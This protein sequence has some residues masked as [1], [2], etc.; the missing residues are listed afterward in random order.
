MNVAVSFSLPNEAL[1]LLSALGD[2]GAEA[3]VVGGFVR[4]SLLGRSVSDIDMACSA[5]WQEMQRICEAAGF[6][7]HETGTKH[8]TLTVIVDDTAFEVTTFRIDGIYKDGRRPENVTFTQSI[9]EDLARRDFTINAMAYRPDKGLLDPFGGMHDIETRTI[10]TVGDPSTRFAEDGL[11]LLRACRFSAE[12]GY[13]IEKNTYRAMV[14]SKRFLRQISAERVTHELNRLLLGPCA[15]SALVECV[16][17]LSAVIPEL[18]AMKGFEQKS[19][20]HVYDVLKHTAKVIDGVPPYS[21]VRWA[22]LFHDMGKPSAFFTD[23]AGIGH[24]YAHP[25]L[26]VPIAR[27]VMQRLTF[28]Q[29][30]MTRV[31]TLVQHHDDVVQASAKSVKRMINKLGGDVDLFRSLCDLKRGDARGKAPH[32]I[33]A[34]VEMVD[35]LERICDELVHEGAAFCVKDLAISGGD[36]I[37]LGVAQGPDV[38]ALLSKLMDA[39]IEEAVE[40]THDALVAQVR[41]LLSEK[42]FS[43]NFEK[44]VDE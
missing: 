1:K 29:A 17:V 18:V 19:P 9:E 35:D 30:S 24:F 5:H 6:S 42:D 31:L 32:L 4:D 8:G 7:T 26:G 11:R 10:R 27:G 3:W 12:L 43:K 28:S 23:E 21:L 13:S 40:N 2:A 25:D 22:A 36:I 37:E 14:C 15:G 20:Y 33:E 44:G 38:G 34:Q 16:D 41:R 39:V